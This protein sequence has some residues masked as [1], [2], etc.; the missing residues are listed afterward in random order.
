MADFRV[1]IIRVKCLRNALSGILYLPFVVGFYAL[2]YPLLPRITPLVSLV[3]H[4]AF[5]ADQGPRRVGD[6]FLRPRQ[7]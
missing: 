7:P 1:G 2:I 3:R 6:P 5:A 4:D